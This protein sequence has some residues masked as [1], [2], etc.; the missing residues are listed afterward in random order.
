ML[1]MLVK[2]ILQSLQQIPFNDQPSSLEEKADVAI[3]PWCLVSSYVFNYCAQLFFCKF[4]L[5]LRQN[6]SL[7][8]QF[9]PIHSV[10]PF[11]R[12]TE[13]RTEMLEKYH[14]LVLM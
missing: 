12:L 7:Y 2:K 14:F 4:L 8:P 10:L 11:G 9:L 6:M 5:K 3:R 1:P 13:L